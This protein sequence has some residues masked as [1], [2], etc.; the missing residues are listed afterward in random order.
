MSRWQHRKRL[1]WLKR[2]EAEQ[3]R[4]AS[5]S[6]G[7][8][9]IWTPACGDTVRAG[10]QILTWGLRDASNC[11]GAEYG[12]KTVRAGDVGTICHVN[13]A[14]GMKTSVD[15]MFKEAGEAIS[16]K[17]SEGIQP[18]RFIQQ[19]QICNCDIQ[20]SECLGTSHCPVVEP[21]P[22]SRPVDAPELA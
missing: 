10:R 16:V 2:R 17:V 12:P 21:E 3:A 19:L 22:V 20:Q 4:A 13:G 7:V 8:R 5:P 15:V 9:A 18:G 11:D 14:G 6:S 1:Q